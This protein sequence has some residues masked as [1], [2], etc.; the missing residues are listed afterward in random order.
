MLIGLPGA[1]KTKWAIEHSQKN[2]SKNYY[3]IGVASVLEKMIVN[4]N[5][6]KFI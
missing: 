6:I 3:I 4:Q 5:L 2:L 1:G